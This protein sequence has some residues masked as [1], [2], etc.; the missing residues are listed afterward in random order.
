MTLLAEMGWGGLVQ[1]PDTITW[2]DISR[3]VDMVQGVAINRGAS[4][5]L[6]EIQPGTATLTL[7]NQDGRFTPGNT[8]SPYYPFVRRNAPI[9]IAV[10]VPTPVTGTA[11]WPMEMLSDDFD[12]DR[13][14]TGLWPGCY[15]GVSETGGRARIPATPG[16]PAGYL[17]AR[18]WKL[19]TSRLAVKVST[20]PSVNGSSAATFSVM[21]NSTTA[22]TRA[23]FTYSPVAGTLRLVSEV[24]LADGA[25]TVLTYD[26]IQHAWWRVVVSGSNLLW[27]TSPDGA[28]WT[29]RRTLAT[30]AWVTSQTHTVELLA[31][32]TGG[33]ADYAEVDLLGHVAYP[34]FWGVVNDWP[35]TWAGL[36]S[37]VSISATD[38]FK[39]LNRMPPLKSCLSE[40]ILGDVDPSYFT[41][42]SAY[43]PLV[44]PSDSTSAGDISGSGAGSLTLTHVSTGG[45]GAFGGDGLPAT[46]DTCLTLAPASATSGYYL[47]GDLGSH[48]QSDSNVTSD[49]T[50][51]LPMIEFWVQ[52]STVSRAILGLSEA[53]GDHQIV[54]ALNASG[55]LTIEHTETGST[56]T[57]ATT[58]SGTLTNGAWHHIVFDSS[59]E[60]LYVDGVQVGSALPIVTMR[61]LRTLH[62]GGYQGA[63]LFSGQIAHVVIH[64]ANGPVG[65]D[66]APHYAAG[67]TAFAGE[68]ADVRIQRLARY[69]GLDSVT[70]MGTTHDAMAGQ[71]EGGTG[72]LARMQEVSS[73]E[74]ARLYAERD[75]YGLAYQSR[76]QRYNP[77]PTDEIFVIDYADLDTNGVELADDDQKLV[78]TVEATR[79]GGA[80]Q[81]VSADA[82]VFAF[83]PYE[84]SL[85]ILKMNDNSVLDAAYWLV[86]R[87]ADPV[88]ELREV[89]VEAYTMATYTDIL[90][91]EISSYFTVNNM[92]AQSAAASMRVYV[93]GY[94]ET[95]REQS[96]QI[97]FRTSRAATDSVWVLDDAVYSVLGT[98]TRLAY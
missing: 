42:L 41:L 40:E 44:E 24:A 46:G 26:P 75:Y 33:A 67:M 66:Y 93:E 81:R 58:A 17:S 60:L 35:V 1:Y 74:S 70:V 5:E 68:D 61:S 36:Q 59:S 27:E 21:V 91:A 8:T 12:N 82:S 53:G 87:Y 56:L 18:Q 6:S 98:T 95:I 62:I 79:P 84:Q 15:G 54:F 97:Q 49:H 19:A 78:N 85:N 86:S 96:H 4:D 7:D 13:I 63:R 50:L 77:D 34:R 94:S 88:P 48:F 37:S 92:P 38:L 83:G 25:A 9:R 29:V 43:F 23:G 30:P 73:T 57:V 14:D 72:A 2:T 3:Y 64:H 47:A 89:P 65:V 71:G 32:R 55:V 22:G 11:P 10:T 51:L 16:V 69:S 20:L 28:D 39:R 76:D 90:D 80:T 31:T 52:T 45:T